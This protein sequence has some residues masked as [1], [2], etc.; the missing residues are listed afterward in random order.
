MEK[1]IKNFWIA[2]FFL[3][4][5]NAAV[6]SKS[7]FYGKIDILMF[8]KAV[9]FEITWYMSTGKKIIW[10]CMR[11]MIS[12]TYYQSLKPKIMELTK[13]IYTTQAK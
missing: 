13:S 3:P 4:A 8:R 1:R 7:F 10:S 12:D 9:M 11:V 6:F 5:I 2:V